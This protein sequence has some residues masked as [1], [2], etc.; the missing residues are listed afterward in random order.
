MKLLRGHQRESIA[1][2]EAH[3][4]TEYAQRAGAGAVAL[5]RAAVAYLPQK[6]EIL[7]HAKRS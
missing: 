4:I 3:L 5:A 6:V 1:Q 7:P 2:I